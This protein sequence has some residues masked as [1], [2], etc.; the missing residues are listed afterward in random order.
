MNDSIRELIL[1]NIKTTLQGITTG[2]GYNYT[3]QSVERWK[4]KGNTTNVSPHIIVH[5]GPETKNPGPDPQTECDLSLIIEAGYRQDDTDITESDIIVSK[6]LADIEKALLADYTRGGYAEETKIS[7]NIP[8]EYVEGQP[9][10]GI[11]V[12]IELKYKHANTDPTVYV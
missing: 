12:Q 6:L 1:Q 4:Q 9:R 5:A 7:G 2:A 8:F 11:L 10:F 3:V